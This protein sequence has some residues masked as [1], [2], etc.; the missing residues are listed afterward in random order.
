MTLCV[1]DE[2]GQR[3]SKDESEEVDTIMEAQAIYA[4]KVERKGCC[5]R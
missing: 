3:K 5:G 4:A 2:M 1:S